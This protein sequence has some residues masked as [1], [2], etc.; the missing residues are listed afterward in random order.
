M[1]P[2]SM[3]SQKL[4]GVHRAINLAKK[5]NLEWLL[6]FSRKEFT[7]ISQWTCIKYRKPCLTNR[8]KSSV[9]IISNVFQELETFRSWINSS[10]K[11]RKTWYWR[12][13]W[14]GKHKPF[15]VTTS[16]NLMKAAF[17]LG[18]SNPKFLVDSLVYVLNNFYTQSEAQQKSTT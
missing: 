8:I 12:H 16:C 13:P 18:N 10:A 3:Y 6:K 7:T 1:C 11:K 14:L 17:F 5:L 15:V 4:I 2:I 9:H